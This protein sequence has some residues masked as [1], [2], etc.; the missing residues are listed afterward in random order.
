M[1]KRVPLPL[2]CLDLDGT[3]RHGKDEL[4][5][6]VN[7]PEDVTVFPEA[8]EMMRRWKHGRIIAVSNQ[9]GIALGH[10]TMT[11]C[12]QAMLR[13]Q[14]LAEG[15]FDKMVW[16]SHHPDAKDPEWARCWCR[17]P[18]PGLL[19]EAALA[20]ARKH[21]EFYPPYMGLFVGDRDEDRE[22]ARL[23]GFDFLDAQE[24]RAMA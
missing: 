13:T 23:A 14:Q 16:C 10:L 7:G 15:L 22:C 19:I 2:L 1:E 9:G 11:V 18:S 21:S 20:L 6:F 24:W 3:V 4:G 5:H 12:A 8:V 17:K